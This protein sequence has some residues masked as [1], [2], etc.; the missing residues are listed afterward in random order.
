MKTAVKKAAQQRAIGR[1]RL[2]DVP[3]PPEVIESAHRVASDTSWTELLQQRR[4]MD[5]PNRFTH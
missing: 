1:Q 4:V 5:V 3:V 2:A